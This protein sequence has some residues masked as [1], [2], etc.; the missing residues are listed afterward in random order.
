M[1]VLVNNPTKVILHC[2]ATPDFQKGD[3][4]FDLFGADDILRWHLD[5][6]FSD[7]GYHFVIRRNGVIESGRKVEIVGA[8]TLGYNQDSL[9]VC[10]VGSSD[11]TLEQIDGIRTLAAALR[12]KYGITKDEW[13]GHNDFTTR[14]KCPG[15]S[16]NLVRGI[17]GI[18][19]K[20]EIS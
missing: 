3:P 11:P 9:G 1:E 5:R 14:K 12:G 20:A 8:H 19:E 7:I 2:S 13:F 4:K 17:L 10:Y 15:F 6:G 16:I 18:D